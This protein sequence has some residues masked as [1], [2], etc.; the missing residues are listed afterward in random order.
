MIYLTVSNEQDAGLLQQD[1]NT[2]SQ[3]PDTWMMEFHPQKCEV[4]SITRK[5]K[6]MKY[7]Y[8]LYGQELKHVDSV[9][10]L[11]VTITKD[12][13]WDHHIN[14]ITS[15]ATN[16]LNLF[17]CN[18]RVSNT[19]VKQTAYKTF[20]RPLLEYSQTVWDTYTAA[21]T[22]K[23]EAVQRRAARF[24][25]NGYRRTSCVTDMLSSLE[26]QTLEE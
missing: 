26:W 1:L 13:R 23:L 25:T 16:S 17:R 4:I 8:S 21:A 3:W 14:S 7:T 9:K 15:K 12:L 22:K 5:M 11:G 10:Y 18:I 6:P 24:V 20:V 2:L 19:R